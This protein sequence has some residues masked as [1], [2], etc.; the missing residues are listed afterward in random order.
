MEKHPEHRGNVSF[1]QISVPSRTDVLEYQQLKEE[2][3]QLVGMINIIFIF[4][5][6]LFKFFIFMY[7]GRINGRFST[8]VWVRLIFF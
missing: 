2:M 1:L 4:I 7:P 8:A 3:D 6:A 5:T